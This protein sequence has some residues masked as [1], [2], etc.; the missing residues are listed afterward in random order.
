MKTIT[1]KFVEFIPEKLEENTLYITIEYATAVHKCFCG[2]G[3]KVVTPLSPTDWKLIFDGETVSLDPSIG[4]WGLKCQ[5]HYWIRNNKV[6]FAEKWSKERIKYGREQDQIEKR[7]YYRGETQTS[8]VKTKQ[9]KSQKSF[10]SR[11]K[12][13]LKK[14]FN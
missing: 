4:N 13:F 7:E 6:V 2:C 3:T 10:L 9:V 11:L 12:D 8:D 14:I 1:H 5:S